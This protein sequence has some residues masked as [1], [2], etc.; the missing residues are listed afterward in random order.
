MHAAAR[1]VRRPD[2]PERIMAR[3]RQIVAVH[4][5]VVVL[6]FAAGLSCQDAISGHFRG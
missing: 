4:Y 1:T 2:L 5:L 6:L 3:I